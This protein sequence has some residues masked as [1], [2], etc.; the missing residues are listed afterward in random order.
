M[1]TK[2]PHRR[3][4]VARVVDGVRTLPVLR[5]YPLLYVSSAVRARRQRE[6]FAAVRT[7][8]LFVGHPR[9]GHSL[10]GS[11]LDAHPDVVVS[12]E[13]D[14]L[15]YVS[16]GY[17]RGQLFTLVIEHA[18][19]NAAAGRKSW[20]YSYAVPDQWQGRY[21]RPEV[22]GDKR[23]RA[24]T[25]RLAEQPELLDR[26]A[27]TVGVPV[28]VV[29]VIRDPFDNIAT[30]WRRGKVSLENQVDTYFSLCATVDRIAGLVAPNSFHR[31]WLEQLI[32]DP[33]GQLAELCRF[34]ELPA[35]PGYLASCASIVLD[36]PRRTRK[37]A[38]WTPE[39]LDDVE[40][41]ARD[42]VWLAPYV[43]ERAAERG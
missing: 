26:L 39:L 32:A 11:L 6:E 25:A 5:S 34:L 41:R 14:A 19:S 23:G 21:E 16:V 20:G 42:H 29:Q 15:K 10:V 28:S 30:M 37:D 18:R 38:P 3:R 40:R 4:S 35:E 27:A 1:R 33:Q 2:Q 13:L 9:S 31:V 43:D 12:H 17:R 24:T 7:F 36:S 22:L 8:L